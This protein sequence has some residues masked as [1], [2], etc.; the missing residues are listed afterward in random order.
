MG[1]L[2]A[3]LIELDDLRRTVIQLQATNDQLVAENDELKTVVVDLEEELEDAC[4]ACEGDYIEDDDE[5]D[6]DWDE[7]EEVF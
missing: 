6:Y 3:L 7:D 5:G 2:K 1:Q 4:A